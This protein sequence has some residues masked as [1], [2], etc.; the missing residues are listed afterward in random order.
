MANTR[1]PPALACDCHVHVIGPK[2]RFPLAQERTYTPKDALLTDLRA[3]LARL[4]LERVVLIQPS[5]YGT[6]NS[7]ILDAIDALDGKARGVAVL[8]HDTA[9]A[10]LDDLH[11][12]GIRGLRVNIASGAMVSFDA[13]RERIFAAAKLCDRNNWHVQVFLPAHAIVPLSE[14]LLALPVPLVIDHFGLVP[15]SEAGME[16]QNGLLHLL[17]SSRVWVKLSA[18]Y[19]IADE[20]ADPAIGA[21]AR[22]LAA[23]NSERVVWGSDWPHTPKHGGHAVSSDQELVYRDI[24]THALLGLVRAWLP[25]PRLQVLLLVDNPARLYG[26]S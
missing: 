26:F 20:I 17:D 19:R 9:G 14:T 6:D 23:A 18:P 22:R 12:R 3:M 10:E 15:P 2:N 7:C 11:R 13:A 5:I 4:G 21:L 24:D 16:A 8:L 25:D 1:F